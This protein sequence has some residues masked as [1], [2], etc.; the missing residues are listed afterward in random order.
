MMIRSPVA[1]SPA[2]TR[3]FPVVATL[4]HGGQLEFDRP[5]PFICIHDRSTRTQPLDRSLEIL[6]RGAPN[7]VIADGTLGF[8]EAQQFVE[9][10]AAAAVRDFG[11]CT[12]VELAESNP[13][14]RQRAS[15]AARPA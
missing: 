9:S 7:H 14:V 2:R 6:T 5:L 12:V 15:A 4:T 3:D 11:A 10:L 13:P 8:E 1:M